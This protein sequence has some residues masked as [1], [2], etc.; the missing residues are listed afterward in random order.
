MIDQIGD[1]Y[2]IYISKRSCKLFNL[3]VYEYDYDSKYIRCYLQHT[4][5]AESDGKNK[6]MG[7]YAYCSSCNKQTNDFN[8]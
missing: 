2:I 1:Y 3:I 5:D 6:M 4:G 7:L 8:L